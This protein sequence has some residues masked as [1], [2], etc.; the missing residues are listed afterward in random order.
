MWVCEYALLVLQ[1]YCKSRI[2]CHD[3]NS[4]SVSLWP[5]HKKSCSDIFVTSTDGKEK[6][7]YS[8]CLLSH[9]LVHIN[10]KQSLTT[11][12]HQMELHQVCGWQARSSD[13]STRVWYWT[14]GEIAAWTSLEARTLIDSNTSIACCRVLRSWYRENWR[15]SWCRWNET[16]FEWSGSEWAYEG[17]RVD[18]YRTR[19]L[20]LP[21]ARIYPP[22]K[23]LLKP[24]P[25]II[26]IVAADAVF[27]KLYA[28]G[29]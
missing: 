27:V 2:V 22:L 16:D 5:V 11:Q 6:Y 14:N 8:T 12:L 26:H 24:P 9:S 15:S 21:I 3:E 29:K 7:F 18:L 19:W 20:D 13:K 17:R 1:R 25:D 28:I 4:N 10:R 23:P